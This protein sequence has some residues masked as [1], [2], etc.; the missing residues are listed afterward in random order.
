[1]DI[2]QIMREI[3]RFKADAPA[4]TYLA[5]EKRFGVRRAVWTDSY[6][7]NNSPTL[8]FY[9]YK[10]FYGSFHERSTAAHVAKW[11]EEV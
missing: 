2:L 1:M 5:F 11:F 10:N 8:F 9:G 3:E 6:A 7:K 4:Q